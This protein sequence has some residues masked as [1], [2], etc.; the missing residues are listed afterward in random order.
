M[1][2]RSGTGLPCQQSK[3]RPQNG[4]GLWKSTA[5]ETWGQRMIEKLVVAQFEGPKLL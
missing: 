5:M 3:L 2:L 4:E 1:P